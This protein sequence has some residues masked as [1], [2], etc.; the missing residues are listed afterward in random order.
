MNQAAQGLWTGF[1]E[2]A[3][4]DLQFKAMA[5][6][7]ARK[8]RSGA[9]SP[10]SPA[11]LSAWSGRGDRPESLQPIT[12]KAFAARHHR[13]A[14]R[15]FCGASGKEWRANSISSVPVFGRYLLTTGRPE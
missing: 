12:A 13:L 11:R 10:R 14:S 7:L 5:S 1:S 15:G 2:V 3:T 8:V 4:R 9:C 6:A